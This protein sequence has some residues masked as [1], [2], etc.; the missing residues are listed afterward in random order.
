MFPLCWNTALLRLIEASHIFW[1]QL[2][3]DQHLPLWFDHLY[4]GNTSSTVLNLS[5][6]WLQKHLSWW[7]EKFW[8]HVRRTTAMEVG[9]MSLRMEA[10]R[11]VFVRP[12]RCG[13]R[14]SREYGPVAWAGLNWRRTGWMRWWTCVSQRESLNKL[15][16]FDC[17]TGWFQ[18]KPCDPF[19][20]SNTCPHPQRSYH[21]CSL[22]GCSK[23]VPAWLL[24]I[25]WTLR[26]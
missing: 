22:R 15:N 26:V 12:A 23:W 24:H 8:T 10:M 17:E 6:A 5:H 25:T 20:A 1:T 7:E 14:P 3:E 13:R 9:L 2:D 21:F 16:D 18:T 19:R 4:V 11:I